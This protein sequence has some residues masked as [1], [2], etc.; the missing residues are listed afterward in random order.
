MP[1]PVRISVRVS[2]ESERRIKELARLWGPVKPLSQ[3]DVIEHALEC[4][5][6]M[7][8]TNATN[9]SDKG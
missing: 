2:K 3:G 7:I 6:L 4:C 5:A 9:S 1:K 8:K